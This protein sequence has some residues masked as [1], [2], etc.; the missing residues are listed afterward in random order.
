MQQYKQI[1]TPQ[2]MYKIYAID[3]KYRYV[4]KEARKELKN[5]RSIS[6]S[7]KR[8]IES[9]KSLVDNKLPRINNRKRVTMFPAIWVKW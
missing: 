1:H 9:A 3:Y 4:D 7:T 8:V 6:I 2:K 5:Q